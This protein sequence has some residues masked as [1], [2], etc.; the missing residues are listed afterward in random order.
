MSYVNI[1][2][3]KGVNS[4]TRFSTLVREAYKYIAQFDAPAEKVSFIYW[5]EE[6]GRQ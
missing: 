6:G 3:Q 4:C 2:H 5:W 1:E